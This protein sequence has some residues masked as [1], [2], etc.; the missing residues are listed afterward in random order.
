MF[1]FSLSLSSLSAMNAISMQWVCQVFGFYIGPSQE[2]VRHWHE[3]TEISNSG[4]LYQLGDFI[5]LLLFCAGSYTVKPITFGFQINIIKSSDAGNYIISITDEGSSITEQISN[6]P[7]ERVSYDIKH[8]KPC[9]EYKHHV[10]F[11]DSSNMTTF[12]NKT[13]NTTTTSAMSE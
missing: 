11:I 3:Q 4:G 7:S 8:L 9:T 2:H 13:E 6:S 12:C 1:L 5:M 10:T